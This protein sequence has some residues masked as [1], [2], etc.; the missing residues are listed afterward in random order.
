MHKR[1]TG[2]VRN[3]SLAAAWH[4]S[5]AV[6]CMRRPKELLLVRLAHLHLHLVLALHHLLPM[7]V[8]LV[9]IV[10]GRRWTQ[11]YTWLI[12]KHLLLLLVV[13]LLLLGCRHHGGVC[14]WMHQ[15]LWPIVLST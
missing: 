1:R 15:M 12:S 5:I 11:L 9:L 13:M 4:W 7:T 6:H 14:R 8:L 2:I 3:G 10:Q